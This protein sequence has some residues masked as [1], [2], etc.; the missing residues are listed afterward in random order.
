MSLKILSP[1][2]PCF[3]LLGDNIIFCRDIVSV[4][5]DDIANG[6]KVKVLLPVLATLT[7]CRNNSCLPSIFTGQDDMIHLSLYLCDL[8]LN[9]NCPAASASI[10]RR[11]A[12][13]C[14]FSI[15]VSNASKDDHPPIPQV[16]LQ[17]TIS[18]SIWKALHQSGGE[19]NM[20]TRV[21]CFYDAVCLA[22]VMVCRRSDKCFCL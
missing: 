12:I 21:E 14:L 4:V 17:E 6:W 20:S 9:K 16:L 3:E 1:L 18:P 10:T 11:A 8:I 7:C 5:V 22:A 19:V 2:T 15:L 13:S